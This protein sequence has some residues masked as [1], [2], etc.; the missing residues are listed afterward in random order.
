MA[1]RW[2]F[3]IDRGGTFTD[4]IGVDPDGRRHVTKVLSGPDA[5]LRGIRA[6]RGLPDDAPV[7]P[8]DVRLG[9]TLATN[10]LLER[11]GT[12]CALVITRGFGDIV[13]IGDQSRPELFAPTI[14]RP[15]VLYDA[16]V[17]VDARADPEGR[18]LAEPDEASTREALAG[19]H[20]R[21]IGAVAIVV[22]HGHRAP[23]L[24]RT[25]GGWAR[26]V[27][28][29]RVSLSHEIAPETGLLGRADTTLVDAYLT[30]VLQRYLAD[31]ARSLPGSRL[32]LMQS[33]G[34]LTSP[35][36]FTGHNA[37]LSG[38]AGGAVACAAIARRWAPTGVIGL[39]MGGTSTD[40]CRAVDPAHTGE[41][42]AVAHAYETSIAGVRV[43]SPMVQVHTIAAGGGS[44]CRL[45]D[46]R[47]TVGPDS[48][49]ATP[50]PLC[51]G[52]PSARD[53]ALTDVNVVLGRLHPR[54]FAL[55][56]QPARAHAALQTIADAVG[57][58][59]PAQIAEGFFDVA[60]EQMAG[61]IRRVS[62]ERGHDASAHG[63]V[64]FGGAGAQHACAVARRLRMRTIWL[65]PLAG[66]MSAWG[67]GLAPVTWHG[68]EA[69]GPLPIAELATAWTAADALVE[70]GR[71]QLL[72]D[73]GVAAPRVRALPMADVRY[74]GTDVA[75]TL[76]M[77]EDGSADDLAARFGERYARRF[78]FARDDRDIEITAV[79]VALTADAGDAD[80][81]DAGVTAPAAALDPRPHAASS[82]HRLWHGGRW[83]DAAVVDRETLTEGAT[84]DGPALVLE[85]TATPSSPTS[86]R[87]RPRPRT[88]A[89]T[90]FGCR[91]SPT[92]SCRSPSRWARCCGAPRCPRTS[93]SAWIFRARSSTVR[94]DWSPTPRTCPCTSGRWARPWPPWPRPIPSRRRATCSPPTTPPSGAR[95][96]PTSPS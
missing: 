38:P 54:R 13:R 87:R 18:V 5:P 24:E 74:V 50:G 11:R 26:E 27:G 52:D 84:L 1:P 6:L 58:R 15:A 46:G 94:A 37:I 91:C 53:L 45:H 39:D 3:W 47:L 63:L 42:T 88:R 35:A 17:E 8:C 76:P 28:F 60:V 7:E 65:H 25:L 75:L 69:I 14:V 83:H 72:R 20:A 34:G 2:Q 80:A 66:V 93:A 55:P 73:D 57:D 31:L 82:T 10:A 33:S 79:R 21:G 67:I 12:S 36:R 85:D 44:I 71:A 41:D 56:L 68:V 19:L 32:R 61:A 49:G 51:Y 59:S 29:A 86:P 9:T 16:V 43:R 4:C 23:A 30:P 64:V 92:A 22:L 96:C 81:G 95:T 89:A 40:V 78:G 62:I 90:R 48:A 77:T 70:R